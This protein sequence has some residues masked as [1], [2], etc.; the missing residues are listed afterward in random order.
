MTAPGEY[1]ATQS[2]VVENFGQTTLASVNVQ[3]SLAVAFPPPAEVAV[4]EVHSPDFSVD[5]DFDGTTQL[6]LLSGS[7]SLAPGERGVVTLRLRIVPDGGGAWFETRVLA[8]AATPDGSTVS[9]FS[10]AGANPDAN[11]NGDPSDDH[12]A[13]EVLLASTNLSGFAEGTVRLSALPIDLDIT[14]LLFNTSIRIDSF[15]ARL[16]AKLTNTVF[17]LL[18][19]AASSPF[20]EAAAQ[21]TL[22]LNPSTVQFVSRQTTL[23]VDALGVG[24][25]DTLYLAALPTSSY[26]LIRLSGAVEAF[27]LEA[28]VRV[29]VCP[30]EFWDTTVCVDWRWDLCDVPLGACVSFTGS[31]GFTSFELTARD[32]PLLV[33][34]LGPGATLDVRIE[35]TTD[36]KALTPTLRYAPQW[37]ICPEIVLLGEI[38]LAAPSPGVSAIRIYGAKVEVPVGDVVFR[39]ADSFGDNKN[40]A[41]T[42]KAAYFESFGLETALDACCGSPGRV[43]GTVY[44][45]RSPAPSGGLLGVG[46]IE[47]LAEIPFGLHV[48]AAFTVEFRPATPT[49][50][51]TARLRSQW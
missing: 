5:P 19:F 17:D 28:V 49:W 30:V 34:V 22:V 27:D 25:S 48:V 41:V 42:G 2:I 9:D 50:T 10:T 1:L 23:T 32:I 40:A 51:F 11:G 45:E 33:N 47:G 12:R 38:A 3:Q 31:A 18:T 20:G 26:N 7:D 24:I 39:V 14:S 6:R 46:L 44:I 8:L 13:T 37:T 15:S 21:T 29:G 16:D 36:E 4:V 35:Y 43:K